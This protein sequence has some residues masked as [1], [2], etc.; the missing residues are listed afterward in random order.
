MMKRIVLAALLFA[1]A[2]DYDFLRG[3]RDTSTQAFNRWWRFRCDWVVLD[4]EVAQAEG[5]ATNRRFT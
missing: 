1:S 4:D 2:N 3:M 5:V